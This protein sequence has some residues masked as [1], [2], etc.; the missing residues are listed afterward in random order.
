MVIF[1]AKSHLS[2]L[3]SQVRIWK[4][5][6]GSSAQRIPCDSFVQKL[7]WEIKLP[8]AISGQQNAITSVDVD[9]DTVADVIIGFDSGFYSCD[10][11]KEKLMLHDQCFIFSAFSSYVAIYDF[12]FP[13]HT[14]GGSAC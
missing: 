1:L 11:I 13:K 3:M 14:N 4:P 6:Q 2:T 5:L 10:L 7:V 9:N 8:H 12:I